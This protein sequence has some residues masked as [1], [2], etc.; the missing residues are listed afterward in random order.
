VK[1]DLHAAFACSPAR[2][3][4]FKGRETERFVGGDNQGN[5]QPGLDHNSNDAQEIASGEKNGNLN[6]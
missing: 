3:V 2:K 6:N 5:F 1:L 4:Q